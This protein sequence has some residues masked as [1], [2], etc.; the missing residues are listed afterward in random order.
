MG[1]SVV[2]LG[3]RATASKPQFKDISQSEVLVACG[4]GVG[5]HLD[6]AQNL[7][8]SPLVDPG[9]ADRN[10]PVGQ[11]GKIVSPILYIA[12]GI[13]GYLQQ[14]EVLKNVDFMVNIN[15]QA[16]INY[17]ADLVVV[18][19]AVEFMKQKHAKIETASS[20]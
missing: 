13:S 15:K 4:K 8:D 10:Q 17:L 2:S 9:Y 19:D 14:I 11:S 1:Q 18:G 7:A 5:A 16:P 20:K 3:L 12:L 6:L